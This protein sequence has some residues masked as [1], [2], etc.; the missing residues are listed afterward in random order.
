MTVKYTGNVNAPSN[1][2]WY[3]SMMLNYLWLQTN[4]PIGHVTLVT[5]FRYKFVVHIHRFIH[6]SFHYC[7]HIILQWWRRASPFHS[8]DHSKLFQL[9]WPLMNRIVTSINSKCHWAS[10]CSSKWCKKGC[11]MCYPV[12]GLMHIKEPLLLIIKS[13]PCG[14]SRFPLPEWS[15]P[16]SDAI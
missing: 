4:I 5:Y 7:I 6:N 1:L 14:S 10:S 12:C 8:I 3:T 9:Q 11:G 2:M 15:F 16:M 13:S